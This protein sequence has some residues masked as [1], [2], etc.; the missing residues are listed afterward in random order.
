MKLFK[1]NYILLSLI[2]VA[3]A[4]SKEEDETPQVTDNEPKPI[5]AFGYSLVDEDDPFTFKFNNQ[6]SD[7]KESRWSFADDSTS[8]DASP[9]HTFLRTGSYLVKLIVLNG[10]EYWA[11]REEEITISPSNLIQVN[12]ERVSN[13]KLQLTY[14]S[15]MQTAKSE[16]LDGYQD[17]APTLSSEESIDLEFEEGTFKE[18]KLKLTTPKG[19]SA[20]L[21]LFV[22]ETGLINDVTDL[23]NTFTISHENSGGADGNEGSKKLIDNNTSTKVFIG[24]VGTALNWTFSYQEPQLINGYSMTSGNDAPERDPKSWKIEGSIDGENWTVVD[25]RS[26]QAWETRRLSRTF[27]FNN[28]TLYN[29]YRFSILELTSGNNFQMSELRLLEIP[30][31]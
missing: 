28:S 1:L 20:F 14:Q 24:N 17:G 18:I 15:D 21:D 11:Q 26:E 9:T 22:S 19:S 10:E 4:C 5:A 16:W 12:T 27:T 31:E 7:F 30:K 3:S 23:D 6:S 25:E 2:I 8:S 13:G 29:Y